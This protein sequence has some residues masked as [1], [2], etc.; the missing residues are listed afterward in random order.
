MLMGANLRLSLWEAG[1]CNGSSRTKEVNH[2]KFESLFFIPNVQHHNTSA[3]SANMLIGR[4]GHLAGP[5]MG[6]QIQIVSRLWLDTLEGSMDGGEDGV[7]Y[8]KCILAVF[9]T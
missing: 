2:G 9:F 6:N 3:W 1:S 7:V 8:R 5:L 4:G